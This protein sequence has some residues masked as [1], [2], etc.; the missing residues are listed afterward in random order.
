VSFLNDGEV[1]AIGTGM[2]PGSIQEAQI[3]V[4][5]TASAKDKTDMPLIGHTIKQAKAVDIF[6]RGVALS[7]PAF[8]DGGF[9]ELSIVAPHPLDQIACPIRL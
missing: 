2:N 6:R 8:P 9:V 5:R 7:L 3:K 1:F 4:A